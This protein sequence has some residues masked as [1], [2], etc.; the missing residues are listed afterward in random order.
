MVE[1]WNCNVINKPSF[2]LPLC[3]PWWWLAYPAET[4]SCSWTSVIGGTRRIETEHDYIVIAVMTIILHYCTSFSN[5]FLHV[6]TCLMSMNLLKIS[7]YGGE[8]CAYLAACVLL[9]FLSVYVCVYICIYVC[10]CVYTHTHTHIYIY[11][12]ICIS[13]YISVCFQVIFKHY[14][15]ANLS[16]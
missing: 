12:Y 7:F 8:F 16:K 10:V 14:K 1:I 11:I 5:S 6:N 13:V 9:L 4:C 2:L 15:H 3:S